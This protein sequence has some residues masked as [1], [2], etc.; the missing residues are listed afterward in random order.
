[1]DTSRQLTYF[2]DAVNR[3]VG[4]YLAR[5]GFSLA[6]GSS[7][8]VTYRREGALVSIAYFVEDLPSPWVAIDVGLV[9][10]DGEHQLAGIWRALADDDPA[11]SYTGWTFDDPLSLD[12]LLERLVGDVLAVHGPQLWESES[13]LR[14]LLATQADEVETRYLEDR[15]RVELIQARR[16]YDEGRF[17]EAIEGFV[18]IG[19]D[20]LSAGDR[21]RLYEARKKLG[22][23]PTSEGA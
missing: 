22:I 3:I 14:S 18:L 19:N 2:A 11:R 4:A 13:A 23:S 16:A 1:M 8:R 9:E 15:H 17:Q 20:S 7:S 12:R 5:H 21:R 6:D 10:G